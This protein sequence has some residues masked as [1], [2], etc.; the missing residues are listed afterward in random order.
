MGAPDGATGKALGDVA[1]LAGE[2]R[3]RAAGTLGAAGFPRTPEE[4]CR[5][6]QPKKPLK[7]MG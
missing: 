2:S 3:A 5:L 4:L 7:M 1:G 6:A